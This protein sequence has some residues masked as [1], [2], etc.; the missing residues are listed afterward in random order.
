MS[1]S[2]NN[3]KKMAARLL[4]NK[5]RSSGELEKELEKRGFSADI[6]ESVLSWAIEYNFINDYKYAKEYIEENLKKQSKSYMQ[7]KLASRGVENTAV[8]KALE[9][10]SIDE[11]EILKGLF[12]KEL[13]GDRSNKNVCR[14]A[15]RFAGRGFSF[16]DIDAIVEQIIDESQF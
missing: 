4:S 12:L 8:I 6:I 15:R 10:F 14:L 9:S 16:D 2:L 13:K 5:R 7:N 11:N 1:Y 3:A